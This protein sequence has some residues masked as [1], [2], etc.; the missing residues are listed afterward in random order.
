MKYAFL[1]IAVAA[2]S[3]TLC[4]A[5]MAPG[6]KQPANKGLSQKVLNANA[7][8]IYTT[9]YGPFV[10]P[11][12][13]PGGFWRDPSH[14]YIYG[15]GLWVG[16]IDSSGTKTVAFGYNPNDGKS[17]FGPV[18]LDGSYENYLSD[19]FV[20]VYLSTDP[21]DYNDWP[22]LDG[23]KKVILSIQDSYAKYSDQNPAFTTSG[24]NI[25]NILVEQFS[26]AWN[27]ADNNDIVFFYFKVKNISSQTLNSVYLGPASDCDI[28][29]ESQGN[30][31]DR[32]AFDYTRNLAMQFQSVA[33]IGWDMTGVVGF[34]YFESPRN[35]TGD[36]VKV[37]DNQFGH[38]IAPGEPL[39]MT[40]FKIFTMD[41]DPKTDEERYLE[42]MGVNYWDLISDSYDEWGAEVPD[43][44]RFLMSSGPF[45]F[46]PDSVVTT[47]IGIIG[48]L[49]TLALKIA[50]DVA[51]T[52]YDNGFIQANPPESPTFA[53]T[54]TASDG[55]VYL[56]WNKGLEL[57]PDWYW[58]V[59]SDVMDWY[60]YFEGS[61]S[62]IP[63][64]SQL[65]VDS[66]EIKISDTGSVKIARGDPNPVG[67]TD[68][69]WAHYNQKQLY[70]P[71]DFQGY[72]I[73]RAD[74]LSDLSNSGSRVNVGTLHYGSSGAFGYFYD[75]VD[76]YQIVLDI[77]KYPYVTPDTTYY[78]PIY[79]TIGTDRGLIY[80]MIDDGLTNGHCYYYGISAYDY[81]P[82]AYFTHKSPTT[83][84]SDPI[85]YAQ[86][87]TPAALSPSYIPPN[88]QIRVDG[89]SDSRYGGA[90]DY[91]Q[92]LLAVDPKIVPSDS[93]K[94]HWNEMGKY[95][96][97]TTKYPIYKGKLYNSS[98]SLIDSLFL[99]PSYSYYNGDIYQSFNGT[100]Y[101][102]LP[103]GGIVFQ[104]FLHFLESDAQ[105]DTVQVTGV[106]PK[107]SIWAQAYGNANFATNVG[108]WQWR[109]SDYEIRWRD[110][111][112]SAKNCLTA[113]VWDI[114]NNV[115]VPLQY[116]MSKANMAYSGW[117]FNPTTN[118]SNNYVDSS[119]V[120]A[121]GMFICGLT[122]YFNRANG[123]TQKRMI[124][125]ERPHTG[126]IWTIICN[127][128]TTPSNGAIA[129]F[130]LTP[131]VSGV[132][133]KPG[134]NAL[135]FFLSQNTP[136]PFNH[137]GTT[138]SYQVGGG[139]TAPVCL[140]I[141]N[142]T[143]QLVKTLVNDSK[144]PGR[145]SVNW[146]GLSDKG[147]RVSAGIYIYRLQAG[148][149]NITKKMVL[150]K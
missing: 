105:W 37:V 34:R 68:T 79:D 99:L 65:M 33:E 104:P 106:Y 108:A 12:T 90:L 43:D 57:T 20:R 10:K 116:G 72:L 67:G 101:D 123:G 133:G 100:P 35:N 23:Y 96:T 49:D 73:Y 17:E 98:N 95:S 53:F 148:D 1:T 124:W 29:N 142:I 70:E 54:A 19:P 130:I 114:T 60:Y 74:N 42:M 146:N 6:T 118:T 27:Y 87:V 14:G 52:I 47:C 75:K 40:A 82:N 3:T 66:F 89:G 117:C 115:E 41:Q 13:G 26:Y 9:N 120:S 15:A 80:G 139:E 134:V 11:Q 131:E 147:Q 25:L 126:D 30:A 28:G 85:L 16:A 112:V 69:L 62:K 136:N 84:C 59:L 5:A 137:F 109:G 128:F 63:S 21:T 113:S 64:V 86:A 32:T 110:T 122:I 111:V 71:Y 119:A 61:W 150:I 93:F 141:Y 77:E 138:I 38:N 50:S 81:Q 135:N 48:A 56:S 36:T 102:Q 92:N 143:G 121:Y 103:F 91:F 125:S 97:S 140:K 31:N 58:G 88:I 4:L 144:A 24:E 55:K 44:K 8:T 145:Y 22:V 18:S 7:W 46:K 127:G 76:G 2:L 45:I 107:D 94:L 78:L 83:I 51:Q 149:K 39:G 129:T 132:A